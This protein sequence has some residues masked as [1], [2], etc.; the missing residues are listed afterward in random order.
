MTRPFV[1]VA[2]ALAL[3][4]PAQARSAEGFDQLRAG[5]QVV[6]GQAYILLRLVKNPASAALSPVF[7]RVP[8]DGELAR[9]DA[10]KQI[11]FD[12]ARPKLES[13][14]TGLVAQKTEA[15]LSGRSFDRSIPRPPSVATFNFEFVDAVNLFALSRGKIFVRD[16]EDTIYLV[17]VRPGSY[18]LYGLAWGP[19]L[20]QCFCFGTVGFD[21]KTGSVTDLGRFIQDRADKISAVP[22]LT[23][24]TGLRETGQSD[25]RLFSAAIR[26]VASFDSLPANFTGLTIAAAEYQAIGAYIE[27]GATLAQ[28]LAPVPGVLGYRAGH[29]IDLRTGALAP[30]NR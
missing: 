23:A 10:A 27:P 12:K 15:A 2:A 9:Y 29:P 22:E 14:R 16:G 20:H 13:A 17:A 3:I 21:A 6:P 19:G 4:L 30:A 28:R 8:D 7:L 11:A 18:V 25:M 24:E 1:I 5:D 26:P